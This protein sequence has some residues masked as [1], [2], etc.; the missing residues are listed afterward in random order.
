[1]PGPSF[2]FPVRSMCEKRGTGDEARDEAIKIDL[3]VIILIPLIIF[4]AAQ[5][6]QHQS[7]QVVKDQVQSSQIPPVPEDRIPKISYSG[8]NSLTRIFVVG[9]PGAGKSSL[10]ESLKRER[11]FESFR[12][13]SESSVLLHTAGIVPSIHTSKHYG[14]SL[15]YDFAG[16]PEYYSSHAAIF[17]NLVS[18]KKGNTIF[19]IVVDLMEEDINIREILYYWLLFIQNL[20]LE[21]HL[22]VIGSHSDIAHGCFT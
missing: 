18:S 19:I 5:S 21:S 2:L 16:D 1:M 17:K 14:R 20:N 13:V 4:I 7:V 11:G 22:A 10:I 15:F 8:E 6:I 9:N 3:I 12:R